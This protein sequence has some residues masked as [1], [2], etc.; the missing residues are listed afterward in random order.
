[1]VITVKHLGIGI[2]HTTHST[3][4]PPAEVASACAVFVP[5]ERCGKLYW[6][7]RGSTKR[8][9]PADYELIH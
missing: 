5:V 9:L 4:L 7:C 3:E 6:K 1:M 8:T 2:K